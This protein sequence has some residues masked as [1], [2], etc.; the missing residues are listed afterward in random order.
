MAD[1]GSGEPLVLAPL[2]IEARA[3]RAG[4][5]NETVVHAGL[6]GKHQA[7]VHAAA[8]ARSGPVVVAGVAG[9]LQTGM[10]PGDLVVAEEL[11]SARE[12]TTLPATALLTAA[13]RRAGHTVHTGPVVE[14]DRAVDGPERE[15]FAA[16]G[17]IAVDME[18]AR[19]V[20]SLPGRVAAVVRVVT[21]TPE[22]GLRSPAVLRNGRHG[23]SV[24]RGLGPVLR[25]WAAAVANRHV[26]LAM[27]RSFCAGVERA[28]EIVE[29]VLTQRGAPVYVRRQIV[30]NTRVVRDLEDR[31]AC[32]VTEL[33]EIPDGATVVF[34]AHGVSPA[35]RAEAVRRELD[36][37][38]ATCPL[39]SK[40]HREANRFADDGHTVFLIG[41]A[42]HDEVEGT[43]GEE[44]AH[45]R[46]VQRPEDVAELEVADPQKVSYLTQT[47]LAAD[48]A[49]G[50]AGALRERFPAL[51]GPSSDDIC[52]A[53]TNRQQ[54][55]RE[56]AGRCDVVLVAGS[57]NSSNSLRLVEVAM[58]EGATAHLVD[59]VD[60][61]QLGWLVGA[62][63]VGVS[64]G[65]SAPPET[66]DEIVHALSGLGE[67]EIDEHTVTTENVNFGLPKEVREA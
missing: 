24:L 19:L 31:G 2:R 11:R 12:T 52:Y 22:Q 39:V 43:L 27:P 47:T 59:D 53:T 67:L 57:A 38:D 21:D 42:G 36:V 66:V 55:V 33:D 44:P 23:V 17:G 58:R 49:E 64:A 56:V 20:E 10:R 60:E 45:L 37:V 29:R 13:L 1:R 30:H 9:A 46:L 7:R 54:A 63:T 5:G 61:I 14:S 35:V 18:S 4:L 6:R 41:H 48:E 25:D 3:L 16:A 50:V 32:F 65:A 26:L 8:A 51:R 34:S 40:V 15:R 62:G 28:I